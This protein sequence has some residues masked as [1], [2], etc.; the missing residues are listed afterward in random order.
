M[1]SLS[2]PYSSPASDVGAALA[3]TR[4]GDRT[5]LVWVISLLFGA[6]SLLNCISLSMPLL[7]YT[8]R[9]PANRAYYDAF[10]LVD[11]L[12]AFAPSVMMLVASV[13]LF[14]MKP[15]AFRLWLFS[16]LATSVSLAFNYVD[17]DWASLVDDELWISLYFT[18]AMYL[19]VLYYVWRLSRK[20]LLRW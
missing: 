19:L 17:N 18:F 14:L 15:S 20:G 5:L 7:G 11:W 13:S 2:N 6:A 12:V 4:S 8:I 9:D 1:A 10:D 3:P 16:V